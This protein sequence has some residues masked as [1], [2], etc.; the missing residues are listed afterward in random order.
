MRGPKDHLQRCRRPGSTFGDDT[1]AQQ[2]Q[3]GLEVYGLL[4]PWGC[5]HAW[6]AEQDGEENGQG[7][8]M[9]ITVI[10]STSIL[11][12]GTR[13]KASMLLARDKD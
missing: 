12:S 4:C 8:K 2:R 10:W 6:H 7:D 9:F 5:P 1:R 3:R 11:A 13:Q